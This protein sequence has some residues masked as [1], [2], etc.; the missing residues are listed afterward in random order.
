MTMWSN[1]LCFITIC[2]VVGSLMVGLDLVMK[3]FLVDF[4]LERVGNSGGMKKRS[5][6][7]DIG[8]VATI[9]LW[10]NHL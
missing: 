2:R 5:A 3:G 9:Q 6:G 1:R 8:G 7:E 10:T 4:R